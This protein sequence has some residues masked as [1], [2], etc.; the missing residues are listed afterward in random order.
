MS[1]I[2]LS[3][4]QL[5]ED[6]FVSILDSIRRTSF[7][8]LHTAILSGKDP[9]QMLI[10][11]PEDAMIMGKYGTLNLQF[12]IPGERPISLSIVLS[13]GRLAY[14]IQTDAYV[15]EKANLNTTLI[16]LGDELGLKCDCRRVG[17]SVRFEYASELATLSTADTIGILSSPQVEQAFKESVLLQVDQLVIGV[18]NLIG[19]A[20]M[21]KDIPPGF[22]AI[23][24]IRSAHDERMAEDLL[25]QQ[26]H[27]IAKDDRDPLN[28]IYGLI[29]IDEDAKPV[30]TCSDMERKLRQHEFNCA[31]RPTWKF[32]PIV[33]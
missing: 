30:A 15:A 20:G 1:E 23:C 16:E 6:I 21:L 32:E 18:A 13:M 29:S 19:D 33:E 2:A 8:D 9:R 24:L 25:K 27:I 12:N 28:V 5:R 31:F 17:G 3:F 10:P 7:S 11:R 22:F 14:T 26:F 4:E